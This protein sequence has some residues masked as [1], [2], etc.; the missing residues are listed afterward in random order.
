MQ[1]SSMGY[2]LTKEPPQS[3]PQ[4]RTVMLA[5][6]DAHFREQLRQQ[7]TA[8]RWT[9]REASGG[10]EAIVELEKQA[11]E[12]MVLDS[13]LPDLEVGEFVRQMRTRHPVMDL[14]WV[15]AGADETGPRSPRRNELL[16]ALRRAQ[17]E[18][19]R[20]ISRATTETVAWAAAPVAV[21]RSASSKAVMVDERALISREVTDILRSRDA[22]PQPSA[23]AAA[24]GIPATASEEL[25][26][27]S[28]R[29]P[30]AAAQAA[31]RARV[32]PLPEMVG[33]APAMLELARM[34][35]LVAPRSTTVLIQGETGTGKEL[36]AR[37]VHSL[38]PRASK[39]FLVLNCAAIPEALLEAELFGHT[40]G[41]FTGAVQSRTGRIEAAN[42]GTLFLDEIGE[43]PIAL[44]AKMLRFLESGE[45][46]RVGDNEVVR[47]DVR[48]VAAS[49]QPLLRRAQ[50]HSFR[51][52]LY[53]R[54]AVFPVHI[55][56]LRERMSDVPLLADNILGRLGQDMP[57]KRLSLPALDR[58]MEHA[59]PGN[60]RELAHV[61]ERGAILAED[62]REIAADEIGFEQL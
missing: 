49:H 35:R 34:V 33:E 5:S 37:A 39:P 53:H 48:V 54:L 38:S 15:D 60:V 41:A 55:P 46:Q 8:M 62:R 6:A 25:P 16:H 20:P 23:V 21:P 19:R 24:M 30:M 31:P 18:A 40:R 45:L 42:G 58:L 29:L 36:V 51:L 12:A 47:V 3:R 9:V 11:A 43:M 22:L 10:A 28:A 14:L 2:G 44:Q 27:A 26:G 1:S 50:E 59:W 13:V 32:Q 7:L 57:V 52:D 61:L 17:E 56:S 4:A